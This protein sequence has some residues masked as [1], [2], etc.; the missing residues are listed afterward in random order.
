MQ[1]R[2]LE[3]AELSGAALAELKNWLGISRPTEDALLVELLHTGFA[4]CEAFTGQAPVAQTVEERV[5]S[6][7]GLSVLVSRPVI[8]FV[9]AVAVSES[10][11]L[12]TLDPSIYEFEINS[13]GAASFHLR[14]EV[15]GQAVSVRISVGLA[16]TWSDVPAPLKQGIIRLCAYYYRDRDQTGEAKAMSSPPAT[17]SALW[18]P[19]QKL[20]LT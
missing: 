3:P 8:A 5:P 4:M 10:G 15:E 6:T 12:V 20:R 13:E 14:E 16:T 9:G 18:R 19:W 11:T 7:A 17:V 2:I 1:R